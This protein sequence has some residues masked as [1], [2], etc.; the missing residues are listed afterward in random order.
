MPTNEN[1]FAYKLPQE[2]IAELKRLETS[3]KVTKRQIRALKGTGIDPSEIEGILD[4]AETT[5][6]ILLKEFS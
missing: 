4:W 6:Q 2:T 1:E 5:R 3:I